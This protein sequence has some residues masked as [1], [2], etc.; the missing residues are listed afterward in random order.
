MEMGSRERNIF[1]DFLM[2][3]RVPYVTKKWPFSIKLK[4][5][6]PEF[7]LALH[8][9][10]LAQTHIHTQDLFL[11][12]TKHY[13]PINT[14]TLKRPRKQDPKVRIL[15]YTAKSCLR[16]FG[17]RKLNISN[18]LFRVPGHPNSTKA[19]RPMAGKLELNL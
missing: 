8:R 14:I 16:E 11:F 6:T 15:R 7:S 13:L 18:E 2:P 10:A 5:L 17:R 1:K 4:K 3:A 9:H 19:Q 12:F